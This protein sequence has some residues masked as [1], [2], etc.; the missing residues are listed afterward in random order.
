MSELRY[1]KLTK[2]WVLFAPNRAKKPSNFTK[3]EKTTID[4]IKSCPFELGSETKTPNEVARIGSAKNWRCRVVPNLYHALS[5]EEEVKSYKVGCFENKSAFGAHEVIIETPLHHHQMFDFTLK[6]FFDYF[7]II[8]LRMNDLIKDLRIVYFSIFKNYGENA[9]ASLEHSHSQLIATP[10]VPKTIAAD[11]EEYKKYKELTQRDFFD[12][13]IYEER[14]F[15]K[16]ILF[17]NNAFIAFCPYASSYPFE[18]MIINTKNISSLLDLNDTDIYS[19]SELLQSCFTQLKKALGNCDFNMILKNGAIQ[20]KKNA[21]RFHIQ[22]I[23]RLYKIA[24]FELD[25]QMMINTFLPETAAK[26]LKES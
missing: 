9:G 15:S 18:I 3:N 19:L 7:S 2:N 17:E 6:E 22:I 20:E 4:D 21:N 25:T 1:N 23:P 11:L 8:A 16:G 13:M 24:G 26:I 5:I 14:H 10:F 12:D